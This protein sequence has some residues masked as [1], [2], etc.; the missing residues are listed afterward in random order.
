MDKLGVAY[1][2]WAAEVHDK[3]EEWWNRFGDETNHHN[4]I[5]RLIHRL[6]KIRKLV[7]ERI[8]DNQQLV[9][10]YQQILQQA[11]IT[12]CAHST[13]ETLLPISK[14]LSDT[15]DVD[16]DYKTIQEKE[17]EYEEVGPETF[18]MKVQE[19]ALKWAE[20][21]W[22]KTSEHAGKG[23][24][25]TGREGSHNPLTGD[26]EVTY[27][28]R[29]TLT[30]QMKGETHE[31]TMIEL[32]KK[33]KSREQNVYKTKGPDIT[34]ENIQ[35]PI[36]RSLGGEK[37]DEMGK[38]WEMIF[39]LEWER[40][41][42][43][44]VEGVRKYGP[45]RGTKKND[46]VKVD[47]L[48]RKIYNG[49]VQQV[50]KK[51]Y[52]GVTPRGVDYEEWEDYSK[53]AFMGRITVVLSRATQTETNKTQR[54]TTNERERA[55][56]DNIWID[57]VTKD[58]H[59]IL[60]D[61]RPVYKQL[62][63]GETGYG[64]RERHETF[65]IDLNHEYHLPINCQESWH[66]P[67]SC[68]FYEAPIN[69]NE[70]HH[71]KFGTSTDTQLR[72]CEPRTVLR[73]KKA[74]AVR[75]K[76]HYPCSRLELRNGKRKDNRWEKHLSENEQEVKNEKR[77]HKCQDCKHCGTV[78]T[79]RRNDKQEWIGPPGAYNDCDK[80]DQIHTKMEYHLKHQCSEN[81]ATQEE[82]LSER[83]R[84]AIESNQEHPQ[85]RSRNDGYFPQ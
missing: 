58:G 80:C 60:N 1:S 83:K 8:R 64:Y 14:A 16:A 35:F 21:S 28:K 9:N 59:P 76:C 67:V 61:Y 72:H 66:E 15:I 2:L 71:R 78:I 69:T 50:A 12:I 30:K 32:W 81:L 4:Q 10:I 25:K 41:H 70:V 42:I 38:R 27:V 73:W 62:E 19:E 24:I 49:E 33:D 51:H 44:T 22:I 82:A 20:G 26:N 48:V 75:T 45:L 6:A 23:D 7:R 17:D 39:E 43:G 29:F 85:K 5:L 53:Y 40:D 34:K 52:M 3:T 77:A 56:R 11:D 55:A 84:A 79:Q 46:G 13:R 63:K 54:D 47:D 57:T 68:T 36:L 65:Q 37:M 18:D 31:W 74:N